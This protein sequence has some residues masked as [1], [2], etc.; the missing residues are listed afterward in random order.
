MFHTLRVRLD[1]K[2]VHARSRDILDQALFFAFLGAE[3][4]N[5]SDRRAT[6]ETKSRST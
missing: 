1:R 5:R 6:E 2:A 3:K 4:L